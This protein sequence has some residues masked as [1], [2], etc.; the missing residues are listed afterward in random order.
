MSTLKS[1]EDLYDYKECTLNE[2]LFGVR[3]REMFRH[4]SNYYCK[5]VEGLADL[6]PSTRCTPGE[7]WALLNPYADS[8]NLLREFTPNKATCEASLRSY[9][10]KLE[11]RFGK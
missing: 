10:K 6:N 11:R 1:S 4:Y 5:V 2:S 7:T 8:I 3:N 9:K